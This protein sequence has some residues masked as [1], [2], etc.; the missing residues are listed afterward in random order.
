[1]CPILKLKVLNT[2]LSCRPD[3]AECGNTKDE[4]VSE[5]YVLYASMKY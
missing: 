3:V 4:I 5:K 2:G 1:M